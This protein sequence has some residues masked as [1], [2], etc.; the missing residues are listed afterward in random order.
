MMNVYDS[1]KISDLLTMAGYTHTLNPKDADIII[2]YTCNVREKAVHKLLSDIGRLKTS[3][4]KII[5]VGGCIAQSEGKHLFSRIPMVNISFGPQTYH[6]L[7]QY[8][9]E[10]LSGKQ[11]R[12]IDGTFYMMNKFTECPRKINVNFS[13]HVAI[14]EGCDNFCTY[15][16]VPYTRGREY[17]RPVKDILAEVKYLLDN[18]AEEIVLWGQ[19]VNSYH[20]E[21]PYI[22]IGQPKATWRIGRL[23]Q[24]VALL[25]GLRRLRYST[26]H[27]KDFNLELMKVHA[28]T[29]LLVPFTHIP[30]QSGSDKIL[31]Q[32]NRG[33]T[34]AEYLAKLEQFREICPNIQFSSDF[35]VGFPGET[36]EDF[37]DTLR[38]AERAKYTIS[39]SFKYS[40]RTG[41][42]AAK[43]PNQ[44]SDD[45]KEQRLA[46]LQKVL[47]E[48]Q[49]KFNKA[50]VGKTQ[51]VLF[52]K[53]GKRTNQYIGK[54]IYNQSVVVE[55]NENLI[56]KFRN[57][58]IKSA[59]ENCVI[60]ELL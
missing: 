60:G 16:I 3:N 20:G 53:C 29:P 4:T 30:V 14:Q 37:N 49:I 8:I 32:M 45:V 58:L 46:S 22:T 25:P 2:F 44:I 51:E 31:K 26:S 50:L 15:C 17:S 56:G 48:E 5:A 38:L 6:K 19:N 10:V 18:G 36:D 21:A 52:Y 54:N 34:S 1:N 42:P 13:E 28:D 27:P 33:Y 35:I 9:E 43:M 40:P 7:P 23:L 57:V 39:F 55:Y 11:R 47:I 59:E 12:I 24:E 41:T